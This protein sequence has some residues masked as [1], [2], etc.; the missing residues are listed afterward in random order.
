[1]SGERALSLGQDIS[2]L[3]NGHTYKEYT[4]GIIIIFFF[5][6][7]NYA[8]VLEMHRKSMW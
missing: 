4:H 2:C 6:S 3:D 8:I 5:L 7:D 1:M